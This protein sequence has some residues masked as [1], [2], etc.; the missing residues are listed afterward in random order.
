MRVTTTDT[1]LDF[2]APAFAAFRAQHPEITL[3]IVAANP[4]FTLTKRDADVAIRPALTAPEN[5]VGRRIGELATAAY[6]APAYLERA[7]RRDLRDYDWLGPDET[8]AHLGS[9]KWLEKH[10][11]PERIVLR[12]SS[13]LALR[14]AA[15]AAMGVAP[16]PCYLG[17][18]DAALVRIGNPIPEMVSALWVLT[19]PSLRRSRRR[20]SPARGWSTTVGS[21]VNSDSQRR[22]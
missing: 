3:E 10:V 20:R 13:L 7:G 12:S 22:P 14:A 19:H 21:I 16:L 9:A 11:P 18:A 15:R 2:L 8:L 5:L 1:L 4:F 6:A 17:D